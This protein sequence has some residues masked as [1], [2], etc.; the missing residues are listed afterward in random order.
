MSKFSVKKSTP[1]LRGVCCSR[2]WVVLMFGTIAKA[3]AT[4]RLAAE[5]KKAFRLALEKL[6]PVDTEERISTRIAKSFAWLAAIAL[7]GWVALQL[8]T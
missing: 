5:E 6:A 2:S 4:R 1:T 7:V 3:R 8:R